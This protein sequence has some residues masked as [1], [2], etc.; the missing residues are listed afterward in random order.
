[1]KYST[2]FLFL[3][4]VALQM[5]AQSYIPCSPHN[6]KG[7]VCSHNH[8][9]KVHRA[10]ALNPLFD[11][12]DII[13]TKLD[14]SAENTSDFIQGNA[15]IEAQVTADQLNTFC[16]GLSSDMDI[17]SV[18]IDGENAAFTHLNDE[19]MLEIEP[20]LTMG[21]SFSI[22]ITYE[23]HGHNPNNYA[24][25]LHHLS[26][27]ELFNY[28]PLTYSFTQPFGANLWF[29][30]KQVLNDKIDSLHLFVTTDSAYK[31]S[32]NGILSDE[33]DLGNGKTRYEWKTKHPLA[34][35][36]VA[37]NVFDYAEYN[38]YTLPDGFADSIFIQ[39]FM[40]DQDHIDAM[41]SEID[42]T[43][44]AMNLYC[45]LFGMYPFQDEKYGHSIW[46]KGFG[47]EHQ[48][49]T[50]MP[51]EIDFRRLSHELSHQ[52]FGNSV[53]CGSWQDIWLN[54]GFATY[55]DYLALKLLVSDEVGEARMQYYHTKAMT[56][57]GGSVYIPEEE[58]NNPSRIFNYYLSYCKAGAVI[59]MLRWEL[60]D[61][62]IFWQ[63]LHQYLEEYKDSFAT[64]EDFREVLE[65]AT[66]DD[67]Y[68]FFEQWIYGE[69][70]PTLY[71]YWYQ[72]N[73][74]LTL[75]MNEHT[76]QTGA[77]SLFQ[78]L[79]PYKLK[80][81]GGEDSLILLQQVQRNQIFKVFMPYEVNTVIVDPENELLN[82]EGEFINYDPNGIDDHE[83]I[84]CRAYPNPF[85]SQLKI[86]ISSEHSGFTISMYDGT[87][88]SVHSVTTDQQEYMLNTSAFRT[89]MYYLNIR[90]V[91]GASYGQKL[92]KY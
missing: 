31:V 78:M 54:E 21:E 10:D 43:H 48:T 53:T 40:V 30:C 34:Y 89:G 51:Y 46:G 64:T 36:L 25:G 55:F 67:Y 59:K 22:I 47:M 20:P 63:V 49:M 28:K 82:G 71:G 8:H 45:N 76:S 60:Q 56:N 4:Y 61:D 7:D 81:E 26:G 11:D 14:I 38:F 35:Y 15:L 24:G 27:D 83:I 3:M 65:E 66:G 84:S 44:D 50:S 18:S 16:I 90:S 62:D 9:L 6:E 73:D 87:G 39:N 88:K 33:V 52:W 13:F 79:I 74:T 42:K 2:P 68:W 58:A 85:S 70:Y 1:M 72:H 69:G 57:P 37:F 12:Y 86:S 23:G 41:K 77:T 80:L 5:S 19:I 32:A 75:K 29:P 17:A 92:F 91:G